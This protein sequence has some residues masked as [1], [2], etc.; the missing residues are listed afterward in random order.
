MDIRYN[1]TLVNSQTLNKNT[2]QKEPE[3]TINKP[4]ASY[5]SVIMIDLDAP[6]GKTDKS[7]SFLHWWVA[8]IDLSKNFN[9][10]WVPYFPP[11]PPSGTGA[12]RYVFYLYKQP[13]LLEKPYNLNSIT[14]RDKFNLSAVSSSLGL[15]LL[16]IRQ[17]VTTY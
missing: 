10:I 15:Q 3:V 16:D 14:S 13:K 8:N 11:T 17:F 5:Y 9:Q 6:P 2:V 12:H 7:I 1:N 4:V